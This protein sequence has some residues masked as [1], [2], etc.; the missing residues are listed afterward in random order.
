MRQTAIFVLIKG[1]IIF[2]ILIFIWYYLYLYN[3]EPSFS[4]NRLKEERKQA[5][6]LNLK[7]SVL[8]EL[9]EKEKFNDLS[10]LK[11]EEKWKKEIFKDF[12]KNY[13]R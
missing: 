10:D 6:F 2:S 12:N 11:D 1:I 3:A 4:E 8:L 7:E 9:K 13:Y 5:E